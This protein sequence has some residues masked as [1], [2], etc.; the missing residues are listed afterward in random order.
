MVISLLAATKM[1]LATT[2]ERRAT[3]GNRYAKILNEAEED[4]FFKT[5]YGGFIEEDND[6]DYK[7]EKEVEDVTDSDISIDENDEVVSGNED[8]EPRKTRKAGLFTKAYKEPRPVPSVKPSVDAKEPKKKKMSLAFARKLRNEKL[9]RKSIRRSTAAKSA[10]T[11]ERVKSRI[12]IEKK[13]KMRRT[14]RQET[15][16]TQEQLLKEAKITEEE[17]LKSLEKFQ[18]MELEKKKIR[19]VRKAPTG[20]V[21]RYHSVAMPIIKVMG[22]EG[23]QK[24]KVEA[25][26]E[27]TFLTFEDSQQFKNIFRKSKPKV[28]TLYCPVTRFVI[29][30]F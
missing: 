2:R 24:E 7:E 14:P 26:C 1:S 5:T 28:N 21:V 18:K 8:D 19:F 25:K 30:L 11:R 17:N 10:A 9:E 4:E 22:N 27:R 16:L 3:A 29:L 13:R 12:E 15:R 6:C 20:P 23:G